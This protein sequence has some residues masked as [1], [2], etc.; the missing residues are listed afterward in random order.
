MTF[1]KEVIAQYNLE[2]N[3]KVKVTDDLTS[4]NRSN[5]SR[6]HD[7]PEV[8]HNVRM[9]NS[10][11]QFALSTNSKEWKSVLNPWGRSLKEMTTALVDPSTRLFNK[12]ILDETP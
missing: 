4:V 9:R 8:D 10:K 1:K 3:T 11:V 12:L 5:M 2:H 6:L 7:L